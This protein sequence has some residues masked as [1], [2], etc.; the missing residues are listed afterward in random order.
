VEYALSASQIST[1]L[2]CA[3]KYAFRYVER[4]EPETQAAALS[5]GSAVHSAIDWF[6]QERMD[7]RTP[8]G[9]DVAK[10]FRADWEAAQEDEIE[11]DDGTDA[12]VMRERGETLV[13]LYVGRFRDAAVVGTEIAF[14]TPLVD[15]ETGEVF[16][17]NVRGYFDA[18]FENDRLIEIKTTARRFDA[19]T[20]RRKLQLSFYAWAYRR[21]RK[22]EPVI[23]VVSLLKTRNP[24]IDVVETPRTI[25]DDAF[26]VHLAVEVAR[27][28]EAR[29]FPPNPGWMCSGCEYAMACE[30]WRGSGV[31][32]GNA[33]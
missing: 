8:A 10:V 2:M 4:I 9:A 11:F 17:W 3:R 19:E 22:R 12:T 25:A 33:A 24:A 32:V 20:L 18:I 15:P 31:S 1:Y 29:V 7:G 23:T 13:H 6:H 30:K 21:L 14:E 27:G 28:I 16:P 5:F 26:A